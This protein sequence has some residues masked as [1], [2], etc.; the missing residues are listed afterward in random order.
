MRASVLL[1]TRLDVAGTEARR[2]RAAVPGRYSGIPGGI[3]RRGARGLRAATH[4][5][6][7]P[8]ATAAVLSPHLRCGPRPCCAGFYLPDSGAAVAIADA[9]FCPRFVAQAC[10]DTPLLTLIVGN[11]PA[12]D[13][14]APKA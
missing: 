10:R 3:F 8:A 14:A 6:P 5:Y 9:E 7:D 1:G 2:P 4:Q 13:H 11:G 12:A